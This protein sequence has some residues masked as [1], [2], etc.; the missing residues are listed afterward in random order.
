VCV[1]V[2]VR[3]RV[4]LQPVHSWKDRAELTCISVTRSY[5]ERT[6]RV[7]ALRSRSASIRL[8]VPRAICKPRISANLA[9]EPGHRY[10]YPGFTLKRNGHGLR[11]TC[12]TICVVA[13]RFARDP[14]SALASEIFRSRGRPISREISRGDG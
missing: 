3:T 12:S 10:R 6:I 9:S 14:R 11:D 1:C 5:Q 7:H 13:K 2:C 4:C 8:F